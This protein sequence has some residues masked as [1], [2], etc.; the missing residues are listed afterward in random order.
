MVGLYHLCQQE[1]AEVLIQFHCFH[2]A[3]ARSDPLDHFH[4]VGGFQRCLEYGL[5]AC[6]DTVRISLVGGYKPH[7]LEPSQKRLSVPPAV[8]AV[9]GTPHRS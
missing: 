2:Y 6:A 5:G 1:L 9:N 8:L 7:G 4:Q 3:D